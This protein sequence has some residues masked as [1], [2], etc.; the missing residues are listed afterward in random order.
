M[1]T[2]SD[3][4]LIDAPNLRHQVG[5]VAYLVAMSDSADS[6]IATIGPMIGVESR[7]ARLR[8]LE[9]CVSVLR[10]F[11]RRIDAEVD[12]RT[13]RKRPAEILEMLRSAKL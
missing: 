4:R 8:E 3:A 5:S 10:R 6:L 9:D 12:A 13:E 2:E 7:P 11:V 1:L